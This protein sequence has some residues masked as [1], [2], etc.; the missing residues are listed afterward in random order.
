VAAPLVSVIVP[1][2]NAAPYLAETIQSIL[3]QGHAPLETI[4]VDD[5]STDGSGA[6]AQSFGEK[7]IYRR[8]ANQGISSARNTGLEDCRGDVIAFLDAD[9][10]WTDRSLAV[11]LAALVGTPEA[12]CVYGGVEQFISLD[13]SEA[14]R[15]HI[16]C[17]PKPRQGRIAGALIVTRNAFERIG[18]FDRNFRQGE[19][20]DWVARAEE[21]RVMT[22][23][24]DA[25]VLRR[26]IHTNNTVRQN[27]EQQTDY[28]QVLKALLDRRRQQAG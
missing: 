26:R 20:M 3:G 12:G 24:I 9:D 8:Q 5:G 22:V 1:C 14:E 7:V 28:L 19:M 18:Y 11:R 10:L 4:V 13:V 2:F 16:V 21:A 23:S 15:S 17:P 27:R 25:V 6:I